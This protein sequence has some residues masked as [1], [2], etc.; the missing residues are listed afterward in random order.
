MLDGTPK[1]NP[2][3]QQRTEFLQVSIMMLNCLAKNEVKRSS[4]YDDIYVKESSNLIG[5]KNFLGQN[6]RTRLLNRLK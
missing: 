1:K 5:R 2:K 6:S 3:T 4:Q